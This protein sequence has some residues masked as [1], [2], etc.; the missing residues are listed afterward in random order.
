M[1]GHRLPHRLS[2]PVL[3]S[4]LPNNLH[5]RFYQVQSYFFHCI[6]AHHSTAAHISEPQ[7]GTNI[8]Q[9]SVLMYRPKLTAAIIK[10]ITAAIL[11]KFFML[12]AWGVV[13]RFQLITESCNLI[14]FVI[15]DVILVGVCAIGVN[16]SATNTFFH[17][18]PTKAKQSFIVCH[19]C[20][21]LLV[22]GAKINVICASFLHSS[23]NSSLFT[24]HLICKH[25]K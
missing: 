12:I 16:E 13:H 11:R 20:L 14:K 9:S 6:N 5:C 2:R 15:K 4:F 7:D 10:K 23:F 8:F 1:E 25:Q 24:L 18:P 19:S 21:V 3:A 17:W 22:F